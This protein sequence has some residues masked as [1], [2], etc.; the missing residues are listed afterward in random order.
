MKC[1]NSITYEIVFLNFDVIGLISTRVPSAHVHLYIY[2]EGPQTNGRA[3]SCVEYSY[4]YWVNYFFFILFFLLT[5]SK[6][7]ITI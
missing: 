2:T 3:A 4:G 5:F 6:Y 7:S 1:S